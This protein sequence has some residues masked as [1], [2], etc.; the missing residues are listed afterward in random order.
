MEIYILI[1]DKD[2]DLLYNIKKTLNQQCKSLNVI[3]SDNIEDGIY[4]YKKRNYG[5]IIIDIKIT[6]EFNILYTLREARNTPII[7]FSDLTD[8][9]KIEAIKKGADVIIDRTDNFNLIMAYIEANIR[10]CTIRYQYDNRTISDDFLLIHKDIVISPTCRSVLLRGERIKLTKTEFDLLYYFACNPN[11]ALTHNQIET[12]LYNYQT[13]YACDVSSHVSRLRKKIELNTKK[14]QFIQTI[15]GVGYKY[16][17][18]IND[19]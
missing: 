14:P 10:R 11:I 3:I 13:D 9:E 6:D 18:K 2:I 15:Y 12:S 1:I 8:D 5:F 16:I 19:K 4:L 17:N 7:V